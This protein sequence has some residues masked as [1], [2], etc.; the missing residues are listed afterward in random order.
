MRTSRREVVLCTG[1]LTRD[2]GRHLAV[3]RST[4]G[5][6]EDLRLDATVSAAGV[7]T[8]SS[9]PLVVQQPD[10]AGE[11]PGYMLDFASVDLPKDAAMHLHHAFGLPL[12]AEK[13]AYDADQRVHIR[14]NHWV[15][16]ALGEEVFET[17]RPARLVVVVEMHCSR[18][19]T[20]HCCAYGFCYRRAG[21]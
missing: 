19:V 3:G 14:Y 1:Q 9:V 21:C 10:L 11:D 8:D 5:D 13:V 20:R 7:R 16:P 15:P 2:Q 18:V 4:S 12:E 17:S 6:R